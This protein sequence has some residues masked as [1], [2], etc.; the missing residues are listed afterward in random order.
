MI[1]NVV[2][3]E[4]SK[5]VFVQQAV[6]GFTFDAHAVFAVLCKAAPPAVAKLLRLS[7]NKYVWDMLSVVGDSSN[8][9]YD[10]AEGAIVNVLRTDNKVYTV[11]EDDILTFLENFITGKI[12]Q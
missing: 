11:T 1:C 4:E 3:P 2:L 9:Q 6:D 5:K 8:T 12:I 10:S 7:N